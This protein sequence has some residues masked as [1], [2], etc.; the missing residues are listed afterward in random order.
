[1]SRPGAALTIATTAAPAHAAARPTA[2]THQATAVAAKSAHWYT[3]KHG[4]FMLTGSAMRNWNRKYGRVMQVKARC[5]GNNATLYVELQY[6]A[7]WTGWHNIK[8]GHR[9]CD[10]KYL[11]LRVNNAG[12]K[13]YDAEFHLNRKHTVEYWAQAYG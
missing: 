4:S 10:G 5:W 11:I 8:T 9:R 12:S 6:R 2:T 3:L 13:N 1:M 7:T